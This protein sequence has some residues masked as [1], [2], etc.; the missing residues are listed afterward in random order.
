MSKEHLTDHDCE[1]LTMLGDAVWEV[2]ERLAKEPGQLPH[3]TKP[4][5]HE[6]EAQ[7][8]IKDA[9]V[10]LAIKEDRP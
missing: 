7:R 5:M 4:A 9:L 1:L 2:A 8:R 3:M 6:W 10:A